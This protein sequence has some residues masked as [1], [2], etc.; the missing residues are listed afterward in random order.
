[1][2]HGGEALFGTFVGA[3]I[4]VRWEDKPERAAAWLQFAC[5]PIAKGQKAEGS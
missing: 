5:E 4:F 3:V 2:S 1:V